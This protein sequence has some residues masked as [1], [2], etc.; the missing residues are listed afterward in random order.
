MRSVDLF[1]LSFW[2]LEAHGDIVNDVRKN[3]SKMASDKELCKI[4][5]ANMK[6]AKDNL[7]LCKHLHKS[8]YAKSCIMYFC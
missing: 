8:A 7:V 1:L 2:G 3:Y 4:A 6:K 5:M